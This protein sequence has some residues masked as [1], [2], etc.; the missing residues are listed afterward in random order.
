MEQ[1]IE[2]GKGHPPTGRRA[3][4]PRSG[5]VSERMD[6]RAEMDLVRRAQAG[7]AEARQRIVDAHYGLVLHIAASFHC[8]AF[9][10]EDMIQEGLLGMLRAL[11][12]FDTRR[13]FRFSTY[14]TYWIRQ[15][16]QRAIDRTGRLI[17]I[18]VDLAHAIRRIEAAREA[19]QK[20]HGFPPMLSDLARA[21]GVSSRRLA[22]LMTCL[23]D[24]ISL[25]AR[26]EPAEQGAP[27]LA[28]PV[29]LDPRAE[30]LRGAEREELRGWLA[31]LPEA[32]RVVLEGRFG[33]GGRELS[34]EE[35]L[36]RH[37]LDRDAVRR[38]ERRAI[39][40][41][42][43]HVHRQGSPSPVFT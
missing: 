32:D 27:E 9:E 28:D 16:I 22:G 18:P 14:A 2:Q 24:P 13:G 25:D 36:I 37:G 33:L 17:G 5:R 15:A 10:R 21:S 12:G 39:R 30:A 34:E 41:L 6:A 4:R 7:D 3:G 20:E 31:A 42:R 19:F 40:R 11:D 26:R 1:T 38:I 35:F 29:A 8:P 23:N 43:A